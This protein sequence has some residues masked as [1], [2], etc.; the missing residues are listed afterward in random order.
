MNRR[1]III[2]SAIVISSITAIY[3]IFS[4]ITAN[5]TYTVMFQPQ[6]QNII[7]RI[8]L[9]ARPADNLA[10][11]RDET[12]IALKQ[13]RY[14]ISISSKDSSLE[15]K[16]F[17]IDVNKDNDVITLDSTYRGDFLQH[18]LAKERMQINNLLLT[19]YPSL[20]HDFIRNK[21]TLLK[22]DLAWY[23][24]SYTG[25]SYGRGN[26]GDTYTIILHKEDGVWVIK[27]RP[28]IINTKFNT[29]NIPDHIL[30]EVY[31]E[32]SIFS[33]A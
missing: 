11:I 33:A 14:L 27:T 32:M 31:E 25:K 9:E 21:E 7:A 3:G 22:G 6:K 2:I 8:A 29:H 4:L 19:T 28:Q 1:K 10:T 5:K 23:A 26:P 30:S 24:A 18:T 20:Q 12:S 16:T 15:E 17:K 13:G